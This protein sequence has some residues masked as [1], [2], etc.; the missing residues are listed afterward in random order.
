MN[1]VVPILII[2][3]ALGSALAL[4]TIPVACGVGL[5]SS[6][7]GYFLRLRWPSPRPMYLPVVYRPNVKT[8]RNER[9]MCGIVGG[10]MILTAA[11]MI[12]LLPK[13]PVTYLTPF[14]VPMAASFIGQGIG[15]FIFGWIAAPKEVAEHNA[16]LAMMGG[17]I[18]DR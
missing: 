17:N 7:L 4:L 2:G 11:I 3:G 6:L 9:C 10:G 12:L 15:T 18:F 8:L 5:L 16:W 1:F 14:L 13:M